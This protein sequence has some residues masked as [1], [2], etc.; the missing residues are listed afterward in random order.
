MSADDSLVWDIV[1][2]A[3]KLPRD[4]HVVSRGVLSSAICTN[5][6]LGSTIQNK[7]GEML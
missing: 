7:L 3:R 2:M 4:N 1:A 5:I 6:F